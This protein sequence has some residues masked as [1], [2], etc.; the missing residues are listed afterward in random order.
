[1]IFYIAELYHERG[2]FYDFTS[3]VR[4]LEVAGEIY[5]RKTYP[6]EFSTVEMPYESYNGTNVRLR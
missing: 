5:E 1:V 2:H 3:L 6:F 4:E